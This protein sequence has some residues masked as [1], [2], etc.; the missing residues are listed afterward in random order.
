M[1]W[2]ISKQF[3]FEAA[4]QLPHHDGKCKRLHGHSWIGI[5]YLQSDRLQEIGSNRGMVQDF[6]DVKT[7]LTPFVNE[8]L[9]HHYLNETTGLENPTCEELARWIYDKLKPQLPML[10]GI[11]VKET[12]TSSCLYTLQPNHE[13]NWM[14]E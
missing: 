3:T 7:I 13:I 6:G 10:S 8:Y 2:I 5:A 12:C 9:D 11:E 4:H 1:V 14:Y